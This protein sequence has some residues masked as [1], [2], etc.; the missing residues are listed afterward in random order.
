MRVIYISA[1]CFPMAKVGGLADVVGSL[2]KYLSRVGVETSVVIPAYEMPW[3]EGKEYIIAH[4]GLFYLGGEKLYFE[5]R[6]FFNAGLGYDFYTIHIA[7]KTDRYGVY[8]DRNGN[9]FADEIERNVA[10]QRAFLMWM[11][12]GDVEFNVFHCH[13]HHTGLIPFMMKYAYEFSSL[14]S[15]PT[16]FTIHNGRY[17]G[18][19]SW[20]RQYLLPHF[21]NWKSGLLEWASHINPLAS[22]VRCSDKVTTVSPSYMHEM[23]YDSQGLEPLFN[24]EYWKCAGILNGIDNE[25]WD[26]ATDPMIN[27]HYKGD[28]AKYK[29]QNKK[30]LCKIAGLDPDLPLFGFIGRLVHEKGADYLRAIVD[31]WML[32]HKNANFIFLGT[33]EKGIEYDLSILAQKYPDRVASMLTY[34]E[35]LSHKIYAG[36]DFLLMPSRVEPCGL[37]QMFALRYG[38]LPIVRATGGLRDSVIDISQADGVGIRFDN[39]DFD[40]MMHAVWRASQL[41]YNKKE[42]AVIV[43]RAMSLDFSWDASAEKYKMIYEGLV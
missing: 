24:A 19:F 20:T 39:M 5:V 30:A 12:D 32:Y 37:N 22:A 15:I 21:D 1:E 9:F 29:S 13:D 43:K 2:P 38:T 11:R 28:A 8:A 3:Y 10:F 26:P 31:N 16:V 17:Q 7:S 6:S 25:V 36:C 33:G 35:A 42:M 23:T 27:H 18:G 41:Y 14:S 40:Q 4:K 34:D